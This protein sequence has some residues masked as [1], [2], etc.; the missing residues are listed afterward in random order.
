MQ[1]RCMQ[2]LC[3]NGDNAPALL[4]SLC[5][6]KNNVTQNKKSQLSLVDFYL[7]PIIYSKLSP[8]K[9]LQFYHAKLF[10]DHQISP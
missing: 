3:M 6:N 10:S 5:I 1:R 8:R 2:S 9:Y 4:K 7:F